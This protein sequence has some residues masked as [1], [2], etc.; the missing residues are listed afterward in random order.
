MSHCKNFST[1]PKKILIASFTS[2]YHYLGIC[3][4]LQFH[5]GEFDTVFLMSQHFF[6]H[7]NNIDKRVVEKYARNVCVVDELELLQSMLHRFD[8]SDC[9]VT[10]ASTSKYP[11]RLAKLIR[12]FSKK[13]NVVCYEE[14]I[15]SYS[16]AFKHLNGQVRESATNSRVAKLARY[17]GFASSWVL[18]YFY[19][20]GVKKRYWLIF[21]KKTLAVNAD[22][23]DSYQSVISDISHSSI[24]NNE[25]LP[26]SIV[27]ISAPLY[28]LGV[29]TKND[30]LDR[31]ALFFKDSDNVCVKP[32]PIEDA[33]KYKKLGFV[34]VET[35][36]PYEL[37]ASSLS[38]SYDTYTF[39]ST[40]VY[41]SYLFFGAKVFRMSSLD[42]FYGA[43]S[44]R[45][46]KIIDMCSHS[47]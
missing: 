42:Y 28:E 14:G 18:K 1:K 23:I 41:T 25:L 40:C 9:N 11:Y 37:W 13:F 27:C 24:K 6:G 19:F 39:S 2:W 35:D 21:N 8:F 36:L 17:M 3:S 46:Q 20:L 44:S 31:L 43:L 26:G 4:F 30:Y 45:Q 10:I 29:M 7:R 16:G 22:V 38:N 47:V 32:H 15:G 34:V 33:Y 5:C 12:A